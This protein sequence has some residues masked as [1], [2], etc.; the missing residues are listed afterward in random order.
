[1]E[2]EIGMRIVVAPD[3]FKG[4]AS[5][6]EAADALARGLSRA[7]PN[8]EFINAPLADG[9]EGTVHALVAATN[10]RLV[11]EEVCGPLGKEVRA[12]YGITGDGTTAVIEMAAASGLT[13]VRREERDPRRATSF[14]TGQLIRA[15]LDQ[16][17][18][19]FIIGIG[20]SATND[21]GAGLIQALGGRLLDEDGK[22]LLLGGAY[23]AHLERIDLAN[24]D[25]RLK[26]SRFLIAC[27]VDNPLLGE[28]G[29]SAVYGPQKGATPQM[30]KELDR[31][32]ARY[33]QVIKRDLNKD[34]ADVPGSGA[35]GG[36]GAGLMAFLDATLHRGV[37]LVIE[38]VGLADKMRYADLV[39]TGEGSVDGQTI[40]GKTPVGV[41]RVAKQ[42]NKPVVAVA[43]TIGSGAEAVYDY[44]VDVVMGIL[45]GPTSLD[46][47]MARAVYFLE[48]TGERL[49]RL[50][51]VGAGLGC[52]LA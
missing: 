10:G 32:L 37:D 17:C 25:P 5:A 22:D 16:G 6:V 30:V 26:E 38:A 28:R 2:G 42:Y 7:L 47:A 46:T 20:G 3:S 35:A 29:A 19:R 24:L 1:M 15:A 9:G 44:G 49:G 14:G 50:L 34:V 52:R 36:L 45:E 27:D 18:R 11:E 40:Y 39:V 13:L 8:G 4:S 41:A 31:A 12:F 21:G 23:L 33:A 43:G 48:M 51:K